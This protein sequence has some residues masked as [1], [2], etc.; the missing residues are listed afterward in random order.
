MSEETRSKL[1]KPRMEEGGERRLERVE[2]SHAWGSV[3]GE[4][5]I[6]VEKEKKKIKS[7]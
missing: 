1:E 2:K 6:L 4:V 5:A 7:K 3:G